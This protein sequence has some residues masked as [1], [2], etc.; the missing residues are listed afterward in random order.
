M[1]W[2]DI[3]Y[4][5]SKRSDYLLP[6]FALLV[7]VG[8]IVYAGGPNPIGSGSS[9]ATECGTGLSREIC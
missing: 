9:A 7:G 8:I 6:L 5:W 4:W 3:V 1:R 2:R